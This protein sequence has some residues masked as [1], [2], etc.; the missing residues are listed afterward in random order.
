M[1]SK[2]NFLKMFHRTTKHSQ[3]IPDR[4]LMHPSRE[5]SIGLLLGLISII[6]GSVYATVV[7]NRYASISVEG[8][9]AMIDQPRY[10]RAD[11]LA[12]IERYQAKM[13]EYNALIQIQSEITTVAEK[14][15]LVETEV[16]DAPESNPTTINN[17]SEL[18]SNV[19]V[20]LE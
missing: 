10:K 2:K 16:N 5:W 15:S 19:P 18:E 13:A 12:A 9:T 1:I 7:F 4:Q 20:T 6:A 14:E 11:A 8:E 3:S 17:N